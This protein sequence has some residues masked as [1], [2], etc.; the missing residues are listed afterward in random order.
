M[1]KDAA[2]ENPAI[3]VRVLALG[4]LAYDKGTE[5]Q[6]KCYQ[7]RWSGFDD[8]LLPV[9]G[10]HEYLSTDAEFFFKHFKNNSAVNQNSEKL[11]YFAVDFPHAD[12]PWRLIGLNDNFTQ[13][14]KSQ[15]KDYQKKMA[16]QR[17]WLKEK[18]D[19]SKPGNKQSCVLAFWH[20]PT[21]SSGQHGHHDY[22]PDP[23]APLSNHRPMQSV[24]EMLYQHGASVVL[25][26]HDHN[27]EQFSP[28]N[29]EG[30]AKEEDGVRLF[31]VGTGGS[32]LTADSYVETKWAKNSEGG[33]FGYTKGRQGVLKID[34]LKDNRYRWE[35]LAIQK[36]EDK[37]KFKLPLKV[38]EDKCRPRKMPPG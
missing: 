17:A 16:A 20:Q 8:V 35:F 3:P 26:G 24:L 25:T 2:K 33:P 12:G 4:D 15:V 11:G 5:A 7:K 28:Q 9:P 38:T 37:A 29:H 13:P 1:I 18:L 6:F 10:N 23:N 21:F 30:V 19:F 22:D 36:K 32:G 31:V 27:Y 14:K 34:L